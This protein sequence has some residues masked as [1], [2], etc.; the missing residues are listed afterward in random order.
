M[1]PLP[2][3][4]KSRFVAT[5]LGQ[6]L[7]LERI[8]PLDH[9]QG[10]VPLAVCLQVP[11]HGW[12][13][14][15]SRALPP[16]FDAAGAAFL[17]LET[18]GL[19]RGTGTY[20][21]LVGIGRFVEGGFRV[22]QYFMRD[23]PEEPAVLAAVQA[24]LEE[25]RGLITFNGRAFDWP[26]LE[27][28]ATLHRTR[29]PA[30]PHLDLLHPA[31][32]VWRPIADS[33]R[34]GDLEAAVL[35]LVRR[36]DVPGA[37]IPQLYF[38]YLRSGEAAP[39]AG[40]FEHN[41][42]DIVSMACMAGYL[43]QAA[44]QPLS[45]A[46]AGA[47]LAAAELFTL[48]RLLLER[49]EVQDAVACLEEALDRGLPPGLRREAYR[50]LAVAHRRRWRQA[51]AYAPPAAGQ[52]AAAPPRQDQAAPDRAAPDPAV[53]V[54][55]AWAREDGLST[56]PYVELAKHYEHRVRDLE[57]ARSWTLRAIELVQRRRALR[58]L[59]LGAHRRPPA[60][61][62]RELAELLHRLRRLERKLAARRPGN[63][64]VL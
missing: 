41:R 26:L 45:A 61:A 56:R 51:R 40:V 28:R 33:C 49:D 12:Q 44:A 6:A 1:P 57:A 55:E 14:L 23:Y 9:R 4:V 31:R 10:R 39:L 25:A 48:G 37:V 36:D 20:A 17:D 35:G 54:L 47:P 32:R 43:G 24:E 19:G 59:G 11:R 22:R 30:L 42:L 7:C 50:L 16:G 38:N 62:D 5:P 64:R 21:F 60:P 2:D 27:T 13:R 8:Y 63:Q 18:T 34:L 52:A 15:L 29:L 46:P 3:G 58:S 53:A